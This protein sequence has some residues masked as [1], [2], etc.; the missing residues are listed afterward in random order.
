MRQKTIKVPIYCFTLTMIFSEDLSVVAKKY[1]LPCLD[2]YGA[3][4]FKKEN[5]YRH[6]VAAFSDAD[7]LSNIAHE[8]VHIKNQ[9]YLDCMME[10]DRH[11]DEPEAYLTGWLFDEIYKFLNLEK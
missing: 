6:Y 2:D 1:D 4:T 11:N 3:V 8:I 9:I 10:L 5:S 7:H